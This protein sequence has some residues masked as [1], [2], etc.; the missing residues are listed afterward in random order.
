MTETDVLS[1]MNERVASSVPDE[2]N[3]TVS[4]LQ[5][6]T[7]WTKLDVCFGDGMGVSLCAHLSSFLPALAVK[8]EDLFPDLPV[9]IFST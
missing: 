8:G 7:L 9:A 2:M 4:I 6:C 1:L 3:E 5:E